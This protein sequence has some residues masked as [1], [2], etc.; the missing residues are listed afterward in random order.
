MVGIGSVHAEDRVQ[1]LDVLAAPDAEPGYLALV[2]PGSDFRNEVAARAVFDIL[3]YRPG[4]RTARITVPTFFAVCE[5]D[6]VA[7]AEPTLRHAERAPRGE[8]R[9]YPDGHFAI[10]RGDAFG[11]VVADQLD[12]LRRHVPVAA[13]GE[14]PG[15]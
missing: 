12:F 1:A 11:R 10:Y 15:T 5:T 9:C 6:S 8:I 13:V 4:L 2:P 14:R 7:P 3:R